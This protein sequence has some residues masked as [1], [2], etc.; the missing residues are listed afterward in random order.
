M[1]V[2]GTVVVPNKGA[3]GGGGGCLAAVKCTVDPNFLMGWYNLTN[4]LFPYIYAWMIILD[5]SRKNM[6][7]FSQS[8]KEIGSSNGML[9]ASSKPKCCL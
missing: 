7:P 8:G 4:G 1:L 5:P 6:I 2:S 3:V 9:T